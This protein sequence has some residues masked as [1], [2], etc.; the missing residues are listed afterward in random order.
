[1]IDF[2]CIGA[3]KS[4]TTL[5]YEHLKHIDEIFLPYRKELHYFDDNT[6]YFNKDIKYHD[7]FT[8]ASKSQKRGEITP[9]YLFF[10]YV[11]QRIKKTVKDD[12]KFIVLLRNP[13]YRAYSQYN[14]SLKVQHHE[15]LSF[16]EA[17]IYEN[18]RMSSHEDHVNF[19][20]LSRGFYS[21]QIENYFK[22]FKKQQFMFILYE[23][24]VQ[25]QNK[26]I[27]EIL[28]FIGI[29]KEVNIENLTVFKNSYHK[30]NANTEKILHL[31]YKNEIDYLENLIDMN[32][33]IWRENIK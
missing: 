19:S 30:M 11:P 6:H 17:L 22:Y 25:E 29:D 2:L 5:L 20:Y 26:Y 24:F 14:M 23:N 3:Q 1:M 32:L 7:F 4:G 13:V 16:E 8:K 31:I 10:D 12:L 15:T 9:A 18:Y 21:K 27:N 33:N 28:Q